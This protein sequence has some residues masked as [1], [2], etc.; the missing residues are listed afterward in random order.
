MADSTTPTETLADV[1]GLPDSPRFD[2]LSEPWVPVLYEGDSTSR[3]VSLYELI[4]DAHCLEL[5]VQDPLVE[6]AMIRFLLAVT[7]VAISRS[8]S[9]PAWNEAAAGGPLPA[10][11][12]HST[13]DDLG[14]S[15]WL[16]HPE[17]PFLQDTRLLDQVSSAKSCAPKP[18]RALYPHIP[19]GS[20]PVWFNR[21]RSVVRLSDAELAR[22]VLLR[23]YFAL[24]G[25]ETPNLVVGKRTEGGSAA[26]SHTGRTFVWNAAPTLSR[27]L[28]GN[29]MSDWVTTDAGS[30][31]FSA[32]P[33][34]LESVRNPIYVYSS[35][36]AGTLLLESGGEVLFVRTP[37]LLKRE[38]AK[39][40]AGA[41]RAGDPHTLR[42]PPRSA[43]AGEFSRLTFSTGQSQ[44]ANVGK[45]YDWSGGLGRGALHTPSVLASNVLRFPDAPDRLRVLNVSGAGS[46]TAPLIE[47]AV[48]DW[49][50]PGAVMDLVTADGLSAAVFSAFLDRLGGRKSSVLS[51]LTHRVREARGL[52]RGD[53]P[54]AQAVRRQVEGLLWPR[55]EKIV[56]SAVFRVSRAE[57]AG[58]VAA[59]A[60]LTPAEEKEVRSAALSVFDELCVADSAKVSTIARVVSNKVLLS[61]RL[62]GVRWTL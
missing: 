53:T 2:L 42:V 10:V 62:G 50:Y 54:A 4:K 49:V 35:S 13:L 27:T 38:A 24:P 9:D 60:L 36:G 61:K 33:P 7:H 46:A 40:L 26:L 43:A 31:L 17:R 56:A 22:G 14:C 21:Q 58:Q 48:A 23:H 1:Y 18:A 55:L 6:H 51:M 16:W 3:E 11:P 41:A 29:V 5:A 25:N 20:N 8:V 45:L 47:A 32:A 37:A 19:Q 34:T 28:L 57:D 30:A 44:F 15:M 39:M 52:H 59:A 12:F